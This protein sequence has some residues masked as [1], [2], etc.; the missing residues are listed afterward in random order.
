MLYKP[1]LLVTWHALILVYKKGKPGIFFA[2]AKHHKY[3][4]SIILKDLITK[5]IINNPLI[6][7]PWEPDYVTKSMYHNLDIEADERLKQF[8]KTHLF[9]HKNKLLFLDRKF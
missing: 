7:Y 6:Y 9:V 1:T 4:H 8:H 5:W 2:H 3:H